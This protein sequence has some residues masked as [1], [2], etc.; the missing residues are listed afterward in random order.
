LV[1][2]AVGDT[3]NYDRLTKEAERPPKKIRDWTAKWEALIPLGSIN[4]EVETRLRLYC[5]TKRIRPEALIALDQRVSV[6][7]HGGISLALAG[8]G[9]TGAVVALKYRPLD[10]SSHDSWTE[11]P[12]VWLLPPIVGK[13]DSLEWFIC[14]GETDIARVLDLV[15]GTVAVFCLPAG[16]LTF[17]R[18]W[19]DLIP[20]GATVYLCHDNDE[21]GN[22]G[23]EKAARILGGNT[24]RVRPPVDGGDWC[25]WDGDQERFI[26]LVAQAREKADESSTLQIVALDE[27]VAVEEP[28]AEALLGEPDDAL[29]PANGDVMFYGDGGAGKT[30]LG[31]DLGF[32]L[33]AGDDWLGIRIARTARVLVVENEGP[34]PLFRAKLRRKRDGWL[35]SP[36]ADRL[37][38]LEKPWAKFTFA[39]AAWREAIATKIREE[40]VDVAILGPLTRL[41]MNE[42]G[43]LQEVRDFM[44]LVDEVREQTGRHVTIVLVHHENKG[45]QVS[46]AWE[47]AGDTLFHVQAQGHGSVRLH[48]QKARWSSSWH[49]QTLQLGWTE[50]GEGFALQEKEELDD[51][52]LAE[53]I[54]ATVEHDPGTSWTNVIE[55]TPGVSRKRRVAVRDGLLARGQIVNIGKGENGEDVALAHC[56]ERKQARLYPSNDPTIRHLIPGRGSDGDQ[57]DPAWGARGNLHLIPDPRLKGDQGSGSADR[58]PPV[59]P[60]GD[61]SA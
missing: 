34:R 36:L 10:G 49:K 28:G 51:D 57:T 30:T 2:R 22:Q 17:K 61:Q 13:R 20:R 50:E 59:T 46:G 40:E 21:Q 1:R 29:I 6:D 43:T 45:G 41:G 7:K 25:D 18:E 11:N 19:A 53:Q 31:I 8:Y 27:F 15:P 23:A 47:G 37:T 24:V 52:A 42:A 38:L 9:P 35:G 33:A 58:S 26:E 5:D 32:H 60:E 39:D 3:M 12:S 14:E 54:L 4:G 44:A 55:A 48:V 56:P 16:A